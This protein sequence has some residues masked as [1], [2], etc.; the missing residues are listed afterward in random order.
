MKKKF[1]NN[2]EIVN[3]I[4]ETLH[5][6]QLIN[7]DE[8]VLLAV[9]GGQDSISLLM[10]FSFLK[11]QWNWVIGIVWCHHLWQK[12]SFYAMSHLSRLGFCLQLPTYFAINCTTFSAS[13]IAI[14][15]K[16]QRQNFSKENKVCVFELTTSKASSFKEAIAVKARSADSKRKE[17]SRKDKK[18]VNINK[19]AFTEKNARDWRHRLNQRICF[20]YNYSLCV[21]GHTGSDRVETVLFNL[22]RGS[23][24]NGIC[25][26]RWTQSKLL[27]SL[28]EFYCSDT[29]HFRKP[30]NRND[31]PDHQPPI[32]DAKP[33]KGGPPPCSDGVRVHQRW[34]DL[35]DWWALSQL[36]TKTKYYYQTRNVLNQ[37][38]L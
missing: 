4:Q 7:P 14:S 1:N 33:T 9:S 5:Y 20:F 22:M 26:L 27:F 25:A 36:R 23:G 3:T 6:K 35:V 2:F 30:L 17:R 13:H 38:F 34:C 24:K 29:R 10:I 12:D 31:V 8:Y 19:K 21:Q 32:T 18:K 15:S 37:H 16:P 28:N 11:T